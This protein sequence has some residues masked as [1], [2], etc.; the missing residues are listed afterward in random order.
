MT[1]LDRL[2]AL[3]K[4][5]QTKGRGALLAAE[6]RPLVRALRRFDAADRVCWEAAPPRGYGPTGAALSEYRA[7]RDAVFSLMRGFPGRPEESRG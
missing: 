6:I 3:C 2:D 1:L 5:E 4:D 7:A